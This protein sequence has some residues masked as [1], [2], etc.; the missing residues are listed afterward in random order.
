MR[1]AFQLVA[2]L[3]R[4]W[5]AVLIQATRPTTAAI[6]TAI[7]NQSHGDPELLLVGEGGAVASGVTD[8]RGG[9]TAPDEVLVGLP[10]LAALEAGLRLVL[11]GAVVAAEVVAADGDEGAELRVGVRLEAMLLTADDTLPLE[12]HAATSQLVTTIRPANPAIV[13][14]TLD[15]SRARLR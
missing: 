11:G 8:G 5:R 13:F 2:A 10:L 9:T 1:L 14:L 15:P 12:P 7:Q 4:R 6:A 3:V